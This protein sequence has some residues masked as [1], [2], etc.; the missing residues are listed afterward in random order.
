MEIKHSQIL[1]PPDDPFA[2]CKL[3]R[4]QYAETLTNIV[5]SFPGGFVLALNNTW[6]TGKTT[7]IQM[8]QQSLNNTNYKTLLFN[9]WENDFTDDPLIALMGE[10]K[11]LSTPETGTKF[12]STLKK[13]A[14]L[15]KHIVPVIGK[16]FAQKYVETDMIQ[17]A[18]V[19]ISKG[20]VDVFENEVNEYQNKKK[21]ISD[22][23]KSLG[24][25]VANT[26]EG[27]PLIFIIDELDR[28]RPD[29]A[30]SILE[31]IKHFFSVPN[32][33]FVLSI[34]KIQLGNA[35]KGV[36]GS[37]QLDADEYLRRFIDLEYSL[38]EP[39]DG[40][41]CNY[42]YD[43]FRFD[44]FFGLPERQGSRESQKY[45]ELFL[46]TC[47]IL[48]ANNNISLRQQEK[49][50]SHSRLALRVFDSSSLVMPNVFV[51]LVYLKVCHSDIYEKLKAKEFNVFNFQSV[52]KEL[53]KIKI[54]EN[55]ERQIIYL[56]IEILKI[57]N[58]YYHSGSRR[59]ALF[60]KNIETGANESL[61]SSVF[62]DNSNDYCLK[63]LESIEWRVSGNM[64]LKFFV[65]S[66][67]LLDRLKT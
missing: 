24:E 13:A 46:L 66:I 4:A 8:W 33:V 38:P 43:Y 17:D 59:Q 67:D 63:I 19:G 7:F 31:Q 60:V 54:D 53:I 32:I 11:S 23:Q 21:S 61:I 41:F 62:K 5:S 9:A 12:N 47:K 25:F 56:E 20:L 18:I 1:I 14:L 35:V 29:Y 30:V 15:S 49:I 28:C 58:D 52:I 55:N 16:A 2:N 51:F 10:L 50:F 36:Y 48:F 27:K 44:E 26:S 45:R 3:D 64:N 6:G 65:K 37:A 22:F 39:E 40:V 57:Y 34:D 42:L